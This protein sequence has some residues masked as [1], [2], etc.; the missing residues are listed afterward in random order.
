M[1]TL[2][3][4]LKKVYQ[5]Y[6]ILYPPAENIEISNVY[7]ALL[8][9]GYGRLPGDYATFLMM[10]DGLFWN[11]LELFSTQEHERNNGAHFH[12]AIVQMQASF[13]SNPMLTKKIILGIAP[14]ELIAYDTTRKEYQI[15]DR[16]SY[17]V[18]VKFPNFADILYFYVRNVL[19]K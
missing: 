7:T 16:H 18:F 13:S 6:A 14:E 15:I 10:T 12:R 19:D 17:T 1:R 8:Q 5:D 3:Q 2:V 4:V 9:G 11:G